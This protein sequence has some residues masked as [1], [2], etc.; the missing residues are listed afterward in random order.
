MNAFE[1]A[2]CDGRGAQ[3]QTELE[4]VWGDTILKSATHTP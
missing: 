3:L 1:S 4:A 2:A